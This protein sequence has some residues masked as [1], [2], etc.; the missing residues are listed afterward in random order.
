MEDQVKAKLEELRAGLQADGGDLE[1]VKMDGKVVYLRLVGHCGS[2]PFA[3]MT[4][5]QGIEASLREL[6]PEITV[7]RVEG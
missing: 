5:K 1:F 6:D 4:L 7:E 2:C 3:M